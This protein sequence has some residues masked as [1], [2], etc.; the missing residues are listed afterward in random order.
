[1]FLAVL[2]D[3]RERGQK[4]WRRLRNFLYLCWAPFGV[5]PSSFRTEDSPYKDL[6]WSVPLTP[7]LIW[8]FASEPL[9]RPTIDLW[10]SELPG[11]NTAVDLLREV[12]EWLPHA[13]AIAMFFCMIYG[14]AFG[15]WFFHGIMCWAFQ[16]AGQA[17][18][19]APFEFYLVRSA[20]VLTLFSLCAAALFIPAFAKFSQGWRRDVAAWVESYPLL[21]LGLVVGLALLWKMSNM[22]HFKDRPMNE[23]YSSKKQQ[24]IVHRV[25][26][27]IA[28][29]W[30][31]PIIAAYVW[32]ILH[33]LT[34]NLGG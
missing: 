18:R 14:S 2:R 32:L 27:G 17:A 25:E 9:M 34:A 11:G 33:P 23:V 3:L 31:A 29:V 10:K 1:M 21:Q 19:N 26:L 13:T 15:L 5:R 4:L 20:G 22:P 28:V 6:G 8:A 24:K 12:A 30:V 7:G 16:R